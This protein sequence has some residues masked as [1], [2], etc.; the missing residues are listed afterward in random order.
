MSS[1]KKF[2]EQVAYLGSGSR[3]RL[4]HVCGAEQELTIKVRFFN[5]VHVGDGDQ[6]SSCSDSHHGEVLQKLTA[7]SASTLTENTYIINNSK[8]TS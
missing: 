8:N 6:A 7:N 1:I 2:Q 4:L 5:E 3:L